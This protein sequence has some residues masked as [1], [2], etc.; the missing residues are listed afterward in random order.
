MVATTALRTIMITNMAIV[1]HTPTLTLTAARRTKL[2][3]G[4]LC[5]VSNS[6][7]HPSRRQM[8]RSTPSQKMTRP[9]A[10]CHQMACSHLPA[11]PFLSVQR[12]QLPAMIHHSAIHS[13]FRHKPTPPEMRPL[14]LC[15]FMRAAFC[16]SH[17]LTTRSRTWVSAAVTNTSTHLSPTKSSLSPLLARAFASPLLFRYQPCESPGQA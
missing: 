3:T 16:K 8:N 9:L 6:S 4:H 5:R 10:S 11:P 1:K 17:S 7:L 15:A 12:P 2:S 13:A 14:N